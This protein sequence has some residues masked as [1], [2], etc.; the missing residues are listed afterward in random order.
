LFVAAFALADTVKSPDI[1]HILPSP[2][3]R[4]VVP[5]IAKRVAEVY[6]QEK[7]YLT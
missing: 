1:N 3:D 2:L 4:E 6:E 5:A 7:Q